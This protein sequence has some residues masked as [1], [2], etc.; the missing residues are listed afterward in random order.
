MSENIDIR[1]REDGSRV[2][3]RNLNDAATGAEKADKSLSLIHI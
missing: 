3:A 1:I 2:V